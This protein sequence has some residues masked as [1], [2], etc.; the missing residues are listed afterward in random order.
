MPNTHLLHAFYRMQ[1]MVRRWKSVSVSFVFMS[2]SL[3]VFLCLCLWIVRL[4]PCNNSHAYLPS[5]AC[6]VAKG[7]GDEGAR[8]TFLGVQWS[9][10][11]NWSHPRAWKTFIQIVGVLGVLVLQCPMIQ[12]H[13]CPMNWL[14]LAGMNHGRWYTKLLHK[15]YIFQ[16]C[17]DRTGHFI[18][19][20]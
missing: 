9:H 15:K 1:E 5:A 2:L 20:C 14:F 13:R 8:E 3:S 11:F 7:G 17:R 12:I 10:P 19:V 6:I 16:P 18:V 4:L